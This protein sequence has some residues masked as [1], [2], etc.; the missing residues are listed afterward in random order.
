MPARARLRQL[1]T[2]PLLTLVV[3]LAGSAFGP[4][5]QADAAVRH[6]R[7]HHHKHHAAHHA[8][9]APG[10]RIERA[11][12]IALGQIGDPYRYGATGPGS[13]DCSG[14][15]Y[16][17]FRKA[18]IQVPRTSSAQ[19]GRARHIAKK[20]MRRGDLMFFTDGGG[21]YHAAIFLRWDHG[22][23][24]MLHAPRSGERVKRA[25]AWTSSWFGGT[26]R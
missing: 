9:K 5:G 15:I 4:A 14:L 16:Y 23:A 12:R 20:Q 3:L 17:S 11:T 18:G 26:L 21:V 8:A 22:R 2:L 1:V 25:Y 7:H 6:H 19:S 24:Q 10:G 13:F